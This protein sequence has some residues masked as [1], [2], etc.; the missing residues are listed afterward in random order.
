MFDVVNT[1]PV[2]DMSK[3]K[4]NTITIDNPT[5][6]VLSNFL[7]VFIILCFKLFINF[8]DVKVTVILLLCN[9]I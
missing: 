5:F 7:I 3:G 1:L 2:I 9:F 4:I 6:V 8:Y